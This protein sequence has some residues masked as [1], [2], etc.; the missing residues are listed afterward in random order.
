[1]SSNV[2]QNNLRPVVVFLAIAVLTTGCTTVPDVPPVAD[3][4]ATWQ[5]RQPALAAIK[6]WH[7]SGRIAVSQGEEA[8]NLNLDWQQNGDDYQI[9]LHGPF[10]AGRVQLT[11]NAQGVILKD[12]DD[13]SFYADRPETLLLE[14][15][16]VAMPVEGLR[17]WV[18]GLTSPTQSSQPRLDPQGRLAYLEDTD[19]KVKFKRYVSVSGMQLPGKVFIV[20]PEQDIDVRLVVDEWKLGAY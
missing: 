20:K 17:Y 10:G 11:G 14:R 9:Q 6:A 4:Q 18:V 8:W 7:L 19:W 3:P 5:S 12:A 1:M 16:G 2:L 13:Q 15:T